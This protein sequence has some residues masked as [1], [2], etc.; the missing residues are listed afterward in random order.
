MSGGRRRYTSERGAAPKV[1][2]FRRE[3]SA[4]VVDERERA[5]ES[6][7]VRDVWACP[8]P[9]KDHHGS[10]GAALARLAA[11]VTDDGM[12]RDVW[13]CPC[14]AGWVWGRR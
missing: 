13:A 7:P 8:R 12:V 3:R 14:G 5:A 4:R 2:R 1:A 9:D 10:E 6:R 11:Y